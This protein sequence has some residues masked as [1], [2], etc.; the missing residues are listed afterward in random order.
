MF[1]RPRSVGGILLPLACFVVVVGGLQAAESVF[2]PIVF[3]AFLTVL[4]AP[5]VLALERRRVPSWVSIPVVV[6]GVLVVITLIGGLLGSSL[7]G[8]I[9]RAPT[10][11]SGLEERLS[12]VVEAL[13]RRGLELSADQALRAIDPGAVMRFVSGALTQVASL[14]SDTMLVLLLV[15]FL[16][17]ETSTLPRKVRVAMGDPNADLSR[18]TD[19][20]SDVK[21]YIVLKTYISLGT[22]LLVGGALAV[23]GVDFPVL[24]GILAFLLNYIPNV[25]SIVAALPPVLLAL[26]QYGWGRAVAVLIVFVL[27]NM[28]IGNLL[29]PKVLGDRLGMSTLVVFLSLVLWGWLWG[30]AGMLLSVP[31]TMVVKLSLHHSDN[32]R[33]LAVLMEPA[34]PLNPL[35]KRSS[36]A[37]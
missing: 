22:G 27:V 10:Y 25:G 36:Q 28:V 9:A 7:N 5:L 34:P 33:W 35:S 23:L 30:I 2:V 24:W 18:F 26:V 3:A 1:E 4:T 20:V 32:W 29:E 12:G 21:N 14:L 19:M 15:V 13:R 37:P 31:L 17:F 6:L 11:Q 8:F 16:L